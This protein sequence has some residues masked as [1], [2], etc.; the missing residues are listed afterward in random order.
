[1]SSDFDRRTPVSEEET[2]EPITS[3][4]VKTHP[5]YYL[6]DD[7]VET[8]TMCLLGQVHESVSY[9]VTAYK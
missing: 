5:W 4:S 6:T 8:T 7:V 3:K 2:D 9:E 1:M